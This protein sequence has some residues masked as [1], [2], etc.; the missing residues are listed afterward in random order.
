VTKRIVALRIGV[1]GWKLYCRVPRRALPIHFFR[2]FCCRMYRSATAHNENPNRRN[3][4]VWNSHG[5]HGHVDSVVT[6]CMAIPD[7]A[8]SAVRFCSCTVRRM[9]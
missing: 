5:Q 1:R 7:V 4:G 6:W 8:F 2:H 3:F 9:Q